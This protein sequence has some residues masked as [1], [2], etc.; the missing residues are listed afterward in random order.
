MRRS[1]ASLLGDG[2]QI[3]NSWGHSSPLGRAWV[4]RCQPRDQS[5][6]RIQSEQRGACSILG[7][8][9][10]KTELCLQCPQAGQGEDW[11][12]KSVGLSQAPGERNGDLGL[13]PEL[14]GKD[15]TV[16][17]SSS[18]WGGREDAGQKGRHLL[19][20]SPGTG[21]PWAVLGGLG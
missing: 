15:R 19:A 4:L 14:S 3:T 8:K 18:F 11:L 10:Q 5:S 9:P 20:P 7:R 21:V 12:D 13:L 1:H 16:L 2:P 6:A 17:P